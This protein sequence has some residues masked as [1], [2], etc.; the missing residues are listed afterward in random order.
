MKYIY[1]IYQVL[2]ALP[3]L[4]VA[5]ILCALVTIIAGHRWRNAKWVYHTQQIWARLVCYLLFLPVHVSGLEH[6]RPGQSYVFVSNHQSMLDV[7][8]IYG[9]LPVVFKWLMKQELGRIPLVGQACRS[10]G[11]IC[12]NRS[13][14]RAAQ[15]SLKQVEAELRDGV[16]T[17]IFPEGTRSLDGE[18]KAFKRGAFQIALD[19]NLPVIPISLSGCYEAMK[20]GDHFVTRHPLTMYIGEEIAPEELSI[21]L[22]REKVINGIQTK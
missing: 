2:V 20:K 11:H 4:L 16:S 6:I 14:A 21:D 7:F 3:L 19:L 13:N 22:V 5:T 17:V 15:D 9:W 8:I 12:I 1:R 10:A 18:V